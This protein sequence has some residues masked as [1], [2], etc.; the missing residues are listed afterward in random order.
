MR[1]EVIRDAF[2]S[3]GSRNIE[4]V[5]ATFQV[6]EN[7]IRDEVYRYLSNLSGRNSLEKSR[8]RGSQELDRPAAAPT[9][10]AAPPPP[11]QEAATEEMT[12]VNENDEN[13]DWVDEPATDKSSTSS[14][15]KQKSST[16]S[17]RRRRVGRSTSIRRS[18]SDV[19][20][21]KRRT[22]LDSPTTPVENTTPPALSRAAS[23]AGFP[24]T[25]SVSSVKNGD[26][27]GRLRLQESGTQ[28]P[29]MVRSRDSSPSRNV[30]FAPELSRPPSRPDTPSNELESPQSPQAPHTH[31][32]SHSHSYSHSHSHSTPSAY[33][34]QRASA[35]KP[36]LKQ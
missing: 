3:S 2:E 27:L 18:A 35:L 20:K 36:P 16:S 23:S 32:H 24:R 9:P 11:N 4:A 30:R 15:G 22:S 14:E 7:A 13:E 8:S 17:L 26:R 29:S 28:T 19:A 25:D 12:P 6:A 21:S 10:T 5:K 34:T 31:A 1:V 33:P